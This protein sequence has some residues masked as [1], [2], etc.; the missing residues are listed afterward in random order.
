MHL[1]VLALILLFMFSHTQSFL[2]WME[3]DLSRTTIKSTRDMRIINIIQECCV[4]MSAILAL[5]YSIQLACARYAESKEYKPV[6]ISQSLKSTQEFKMKLSFTVDSTPDQLI[7]LIT[8]KE[9][10]KGW[11]VGM[12]SSKVNKDGSLSTTYNNGEYCETSKLYYYVSDASPAQI[13]LIEQVKDNV[14]H[15]FHRFWFMQAVRK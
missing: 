9:A 7:I 10:A 14:Q 13:I 1:T 12:T 5:Y 8:D 2:K 3:A 11:K 6:C 15:N 4:Y